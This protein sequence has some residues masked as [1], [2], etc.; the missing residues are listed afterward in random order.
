MEDES[1][2]IR[3]TR[4]SGFAEINLYICGIKQENC[5]LNKQLLDASFAG[6]G[7]N[8]IRMEKSNKKFCFDC[9]YVILVSPT[10]DGDLKGYL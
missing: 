1:F 9:Y 2:E 3:L 5:K 10:S 7:N 8:I 4:D 6:H